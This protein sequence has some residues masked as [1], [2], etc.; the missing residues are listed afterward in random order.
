[1]DQFNAE[2]IFGL[3]QSLNGELSKLGL[4]QRTIVLVG[5]SSLALMGLRESTSDVDVISKID[6]VFEI[7]ICRVS[8]Y[9]TR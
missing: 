4:S 5:G 3:L 9:S 6:A 2:R 7:A 8:V 1:M